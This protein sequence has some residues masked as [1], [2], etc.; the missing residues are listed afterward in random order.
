MIAVNEQIVEHN[1]MKKWNPK[2]KKSKLKWWLERQAPSEYLWRVSACCFIICARLQFSFC[3][4]VVSFVFLPKIITI[5][6]SLWISEEEC[7]T[8]LRWQLEY[9]YYNFFLCFQF[10][11]FFAEWLTNT[12]WLA[13]YLPMREG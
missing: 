8:K 11:F 9:Y 7:H 4:F 13:L 12:K 5:H 1:S 2:I 6:L 3:F 10:E